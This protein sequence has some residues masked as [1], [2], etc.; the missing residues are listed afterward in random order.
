MYASYVV[1][2]SHSNRSNIL[3]MSDLRETIYTK[4]DRTNVKHARNRLK[5]E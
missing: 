5:N 2:T 3:Q 4:K 1:K